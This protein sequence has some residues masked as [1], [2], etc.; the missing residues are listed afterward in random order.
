MDK[1]NNV[2][3]IKLFEFII[4]IFKDLTLIKNVKNGGKDPIIIKLKIIDG[5]IHFVFI[6]N[7]LF[8][9]LK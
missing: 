6:I 5:L 1:I 4:I 3:I 7:R 9:L 2:K 8:N